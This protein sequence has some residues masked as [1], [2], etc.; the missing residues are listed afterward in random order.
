MTWLKAYDTE[1]QK[2]PWA[3]RIQLSTRFA[4][5]TT[6]KVLTMLGL[7]RTRVDMINR[8]WGRGSMHQITLPSKGCSLG[9]VLHEVAH[10]YNQSRWGGRG[11]TGTF[12]DALGNVYSFAKINRKEILLSVKAQID[13][14]QIESKQNAE[15]VASREIA[16]AERKQNLRQIRESR[17][18]RI[19]KAEAKIVKL[20]AKAKRL[21]TRIKTAR[22]SLS[23]LRRYEA[24]QQNVKSTVLNKEVR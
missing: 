8:S 14:E 11:H 17:G 16:Q 1:H 4:E 2:Y 24:N 13:K 9:M 19:A 23:A 22:R 21:Q 18:Y 6:E 10:A 12:K 5:L 20:E 15:K 7:K 3:Q